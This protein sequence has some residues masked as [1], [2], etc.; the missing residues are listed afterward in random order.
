MAVLGAR[1]RGNGGDGR[2]AVLGHGCVA[3]VGAMV[4]CGPGGTVAWRWCDMVA[5][6][7]W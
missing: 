3:A 4:A 7:Q 1:L 6:W 2:M 5:M